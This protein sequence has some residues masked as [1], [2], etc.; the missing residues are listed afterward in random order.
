ML[1]MTNLSTRPGARDFIALEVSL[2]IIASLKDV[3]AVI[4]R[5]E[6]S[7]AT[8]IVKAASSVTANLAEGNS[9]QGKDRAHFFRIARGSAEETRAHLRVALAWG[10]IR[11]EQI[12]SSLSLIDQELAMLWRLTR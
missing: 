3:V 5:Q 7:V 9:R 10:W 1:G 6:P 11:Q 2:Q 8:Q 4:R 12:H